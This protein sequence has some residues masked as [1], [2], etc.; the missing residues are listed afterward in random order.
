MDNSV[1]EIY[2][3]FYFKRWKQIFLFLC[4]LHWFSRHTRFLQTKENSNRSYPQ[5]M[6]PSYLSRPCWSCS[7]PHRPQDC[8]SLF[9]GCC[10][11]SFTGLRD[12]NY[13]HTADICPNR[14]A[15]SQLRTNHRSNQQTKSVQS[16]NRRFVVPIKKL[17]LLKALHKEGRLLI[18]SKFLLK[19]KKKMGTL[20]GS[21]TNR[22]E[23]DELLS[24]SN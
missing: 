7:G 3:L 2:N 9:C 10:C 20:F 13:H 23:G 5:S 4:E 24:L 6:N 22:R 21:S 17:C 12:P 11:T 1:I 14:K 19:M 18:F 8:T 15:Q 16:K